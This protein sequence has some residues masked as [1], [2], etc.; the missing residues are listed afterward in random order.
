MSR[1][2]IFVAAGLLC[3][4]SALADT[5]RTDAKGERYKLLNCFKNEQVPA[6]YRV[7]KKLVKAAERRYVKKGNM[8]EL[9]EYPAIYQEIRTKIK[10]A[11]VVMKEV[12][13]AQK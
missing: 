5:T 9:R 7:T 8:I 11:Y 3:A 1:L 13:C 10:D 2:L 4:G 12:P 6:K